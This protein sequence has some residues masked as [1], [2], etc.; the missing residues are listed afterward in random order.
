MS[1]DEAPE[2][3]PVEGEGRALRP[4]GA[5]GRK[6][7]SL[8]SLESDLALEHRI[9][10]ADG[11]RFSIKLESGFWRGLQEASADRQ[12]RLNH[13]VAAV[14]AQA[15]PTMNLAS[16]LRVFCL[17]TLRARLTSAT[18]VATRSSLMAVIE[19]APSPCLMLSAS[20]VT[21]A[22]NSSF[23][24]WFGT[25][26]E[27]VIGRPVLRDFRF[28]ARRSFE[29]IWGE[30]AQGRTADEGARM[31]NFAPGRVLAAN[32]T[33]APVALAG[34]ARFACLVWLHK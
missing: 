33:L 20:Q 17:A 18:Y 25:G 7:I 15:P 9:V 27:Q 32:V 24:G 3:D 11:K 6:P 26:V 5:A 12:V 21:V 13:L 29:E 23:R 2:V 10:Q 22:V 8:N 1:S 4:R 19:S 14:A 34:K 28:K 16:R 30:F 31:I